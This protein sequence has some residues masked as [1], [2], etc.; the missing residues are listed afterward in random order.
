MAYQRIAR[1]GHDLIA[2]VPEKSRDVH[3]AIQR[4]ESTR[5]L[6][7]NLESSCGPDEDLALPDCGRWLVQ[8]N[9]IDVKIKAMPGQDLLPQLGL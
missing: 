1:F 3:E 2:K 7:E 8:Y 5:Q 4:P 6:A 9:G